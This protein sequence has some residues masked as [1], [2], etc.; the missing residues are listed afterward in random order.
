MRRLGRGTLLR[1]AAR[2]GGQG[3]TLWR[4]GTKKLRGGSPDGAGAR[5]ICKETT[6]VASAATS[7]LHIYSTKRN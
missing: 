1:G 7:G 4:Q 5:K 2:C 3:A 6:A